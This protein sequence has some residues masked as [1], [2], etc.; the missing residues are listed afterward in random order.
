ML[1]TSLRLLSFL[2][3]LGVAMVFLSPVPA[4]AKRWP[5]ML[6]AGFALAAASLVLVLVAALT[7][8]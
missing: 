5:R 1:E 7:L 2:F 8:R 3:L 6:L 4:L